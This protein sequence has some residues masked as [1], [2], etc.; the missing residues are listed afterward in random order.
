MPR[1][2]LCDTKIVQGVQQD[3]G[4]VSI[5][6]SFLKKQSKNTNF[7]KSK[8]SI[9]KSG[10]K[11]RFGFV[12]ILT[13]SLIL[14][15]WDPFELIRTNSYSFWLILTSGISLRDFL[16]LYING[17]SYYQVVMDTLYMHL[18]YAKKLIRQSKDK[19]RQAEILL[20]NPEILQFAKA[21]GFWRW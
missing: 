13:N 18:K 4:F 19:Y 9:G 12:E 15:H 7:E 3:L 20:G 1:W 8:K 5:K 10:I 21:L 14:T 6:V 17:W 11:W 16:V 2:W